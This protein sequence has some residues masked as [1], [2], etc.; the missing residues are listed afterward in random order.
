M[1]S[2]DTEHRDALRWEQTNVPDATQACL[3]V[4]SIMSQDSAPTDPPHIA[5]HRHSI[6]HRQEILASE[7]CG[8]FFCL[9]TFSP[10][11]IDE[12]IDDHDGV[13]QTVLCPKCGIDSVIGSAAGYPITPEFLSQMRRHWFW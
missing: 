9:A 13:G 12:W 6:R 8:C 5:A 1:A 11:E 2:R 3:A 7:R 4:N 10:G